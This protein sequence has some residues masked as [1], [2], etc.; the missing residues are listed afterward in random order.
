M[1]TIQNE[2]FANQYA[3]LFNKANDLLEYTEESSGYINSLDKYFTKLGTIVETMTDEMN[4]GTRKTFDES[5][6]LIPFDEPMFEINGDTRDIVVPD[7]FKKGVA[8]NILSL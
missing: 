4:A 5:F 7:V 2:K 6:F 1:I 3:L 8:Q